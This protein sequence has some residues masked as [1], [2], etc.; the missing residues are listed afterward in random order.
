MRRNTLPFLVLFFHFQ[1]SE[2]GGVALSSD[3][4]PRRMTG[5]IAV[6]STLHMYY[7]YFLSMKNKQ[8]YTGSTSDLRRRIGEHTRGK[9]SSTVK[10]LPIK[11]FGYEAY[12]L[13]SDA[14]RR[15]HFLKTTEGKRLLKQQYRDVIA[16]FQ[17]GVVPVIR[18]DAPGLSR[19]G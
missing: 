16:S 13:K 9:V 8:I 3:R 14:L 4:A 6:Y 7:V 10:R 12:Q 1:N 19:G 11:L 18:R 15:E 17:G 2:R 5:R